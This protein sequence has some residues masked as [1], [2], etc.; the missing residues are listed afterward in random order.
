LRLKVLVSESSRSK[1]GR[2]FQALGPA[3]E[4]ERSPNFRGQGSRSYDRK[5]FRKRSVR[6]RVKAFLVS[7]VRLATHSKNEKSV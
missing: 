3:H 7:D 4:N 5:M 6:P 2:L 1:G